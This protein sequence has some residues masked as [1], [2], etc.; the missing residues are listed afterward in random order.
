[1]IRMRTVWLALLATLLG[2][3]GVFWLPSDKVSAHVLRQDGDAAAVL[4]IEPD[5]NPVA[6]RDTVFSFDFGDSATGF[7]LHDYTSQV[8]IADDSG[9]VQQ[10]RL[11]VTGA[12]GGHATLR[13]PNTGIYT[14]SVKGTGEAPGTRS[15]VINYDIRVD[16]SASNSSRNATS[17]QTVI[18]ISFAS[19]FVLALVARR[20][21]LAGGRYTK[22]T[23]PKKHK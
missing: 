4:H 18:F 23:K 10:T 22:T 1:M 20:L 2:G 12:H 19:I 7:D 9:T 5:D 14:L 17:A 11:I 21:I 8:G 13:F 3:L 6:G 15:F 16:Q